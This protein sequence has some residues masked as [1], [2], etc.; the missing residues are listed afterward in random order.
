MIK[1][2]L[3]K[4]ETK[5]FKIKKVKIIILDHSMKNVIKD[6][7]LNVTVKEKMKKS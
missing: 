5:E 3:V 1:D 6:L 7:N 4:E 2:P